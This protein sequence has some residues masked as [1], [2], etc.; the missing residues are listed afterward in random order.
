MESRGANIRRSG[1]GT[2]D[3]RTEA[4]LSTVPNDDLNRI[5]NEPQ[6]QPLPTFGTRLASIINCNTRDA[7]QIKY[8]RGLIKHQGWF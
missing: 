2:W 8:L 7:G 5:L 1:T 3:A 4:Y 6:Y